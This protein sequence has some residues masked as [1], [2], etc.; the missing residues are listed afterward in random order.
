MHSRCMIKL[1]GLILA[2]VQLS[3]RFHVHKPN[4]WAWLLAQWQ[5]TRLPMQEIRVRFLIRE[6]P[7]CSG[8]AKPVGHSY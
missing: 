3:C 6:D 1:P 7:T 5:R 2:C 8:A 4:P